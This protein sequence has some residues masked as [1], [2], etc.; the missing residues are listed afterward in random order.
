MLIGPLL[1]TASWQLY[2]YLGTKALAHTEAILT[3][4]VFEHS[5]RIRFTAESKNDESVKQEDQG[6]AMVA[7]ITASPD[8]ESENDNDNS[9]ES[10]AESQS[11][12]TNVSIAKA[13]VKSTASISTSTSTA[14]PSEAGSV[15]AKVKGQAAA[16]NLIGKINNF[17]TTDL[18]N[19]TD[20]KDFLFLRTPTYILNASHL[21][22]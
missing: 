10:T 7:D 20:A 15:S 4:L 21:F 1:Y 19:I 3:E 6:N 17:V 5:L 2:I 9:S 12:A 13:K 11:A 8:D 16:G 18:K 22:Y 14:A